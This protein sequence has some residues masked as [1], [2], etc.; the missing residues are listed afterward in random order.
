MIFK[1]N[2]G[3]VIINPFKKWIFMINHPVTFHR[4]FRNDFPSQNIGPTLSPGLWD[5]CQRYVLAT[6]PLLSLHRPFR[7]PLSLGMSG[8]RSVVH[9]S[10]MV[11]NF[12]QENIKEGLFEFLQAC[13]STAAVG[14]F[15]FNPVFCFFF[16]SVS[17]FII[18]CRNC[19]E[20]IKSGNYQEAIECLAFMALDLLFITSFCYGFIEITVA[21]MVLQ[22][23]LDFY[24]SAQ[25]FKK[26]NYFE[27]ACQMLLGGAHLYQAIPQVKLLHWKHKYDPVFT[28][29]LKRDDKG[30]VYLDIPDE[31][32][33]SLFESFGD[34]QS[35]LPPYFGE[36]KA[37]AHITAIPIGELGNYGL[38]QEDIGR[39]FTF[40]IVNVDSLKPDQ[41]KGVNK[42][43]FLTLSCPEL[44]SLRVRYGL[45]PKIHDHDF[46]LT[47]G[48]QRG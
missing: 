13:L 24:M 1:L 11:E 41:W 30:F 38:T 16:S 21:C 42:V 46:H 34:S 25:H 6:L 32:V 44:E 9:I 8:L 27:G 37:G 28:A 29:E 36:G 19:I 3:Q 14:F 48:I 2:D 47:F 43:H 35:E 5:K 31:Y 23:V 18:N 15:F 17:D 26:G 12:K 20:K 40:R 45:S 7:G 39:K 4:D 10:Q 33:Y 22:I